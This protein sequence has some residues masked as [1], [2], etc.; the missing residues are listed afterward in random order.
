MYMLL[1]TG[2]AQGRVV[3]IGDVSKLSDPAK[4]ATLRE[5]YLARHKVSSRLTLT[6]ARMRIYT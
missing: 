3:L 4:Q 6:Y 1:Q 5:K 2:A